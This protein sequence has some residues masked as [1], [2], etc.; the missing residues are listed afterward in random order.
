MNVARTFWW[1]NSRVIWTKTDENRFCGPESPSQKIVLDGKKK[2]LNGA[3]NVLTSVSD[4]QDSNNRTFT[5]TQPHLD[6]SAEKK[7]S[8]NS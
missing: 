7:N 2:R 3:K 6:G 1:A 4:D 8:Q 5:E